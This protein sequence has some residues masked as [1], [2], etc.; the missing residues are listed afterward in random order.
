MISCASGSKSRVTTGSSPGVD[1]A[2]ARAWA[3]RYV[4]NARRARATD[5]GLDGSHCTCVSPRLLSMY[6]VRIVAPPRIE[7]VPLVAFRARACRI[8]RGA[9]VGGARAEI[10]R[11][12]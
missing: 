7:V 1:T 3:R 12:G 9:R 5:A 11:L 2:K 8:D 4:S 10:E 6:I